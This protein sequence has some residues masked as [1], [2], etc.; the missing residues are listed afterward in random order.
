MPYPYSPQ[1]MLLKIQKG[2]GERVQKPKFLRWLVG[3]YRTDRSLF[4]GQDDI[5]VISYNYQN[6]TE[7]S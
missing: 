3:V 2:G 4:S 6:L 5:S 1:E 7:E